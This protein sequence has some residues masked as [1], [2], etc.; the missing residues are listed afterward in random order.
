M[1]TSDLKAYIER[2]YKNH[3]KKEIDRA[4]TLMD[5]YYDSCGYEEVDFFDKEHFVTFLLDNNLVNNHQCCD[6]IKRFNVERK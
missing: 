1:K 3:S 5:Q 6:E 2:E 4:F